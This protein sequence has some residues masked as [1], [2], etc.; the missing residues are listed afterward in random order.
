MRL[1]GCMKDMPSFELKKVERIKDF[2]NVEEGQVVLVLRVVQ[3]FDPVGPDGVPFSLPDGGDFVQGQAAGR[4]W[5]MPLDRALKFGILTPSSLKILEE[6][7]L[8]EGASTKSAA[9]G[10]SP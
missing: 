7:Y 4:Y 3:L 8:G 10:S 2:Y 1:R 9:M 6:L 5:C